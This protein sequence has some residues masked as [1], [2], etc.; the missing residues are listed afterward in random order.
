MKRTVLIL[1]M[2]ASA[3]AVIAQTPAKP[4]TPAKSA[5]GAARI[6][7]AATAVNLPPGVPPVKGLVKTLFLVPLRYQDIKVGDGALA[8]PGKLLKYQFTLWLAADGAKLESTNDHR[9][10]VLDKDKKPVL[11]EDGKPKLS[12][13]QP[14]MTIMGM[15]RPVPGWDM[16]FDGMKAGGKRRVFIPWQLGLGERAIPSHDATHPSIPAKSDLILDIDLAEVTDAPKPPEHPMMA[17]Q[18]HPVPGGGAP[19]P[20]ASGVPAK[21]AAPAAPSAAPAP[22]A[23]ASPAQPQS[24]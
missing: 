22:P 10:P 3:A 1:L 18:A 5:V 13:P 21:P 11:G 20:G 15:G 9:T 16:G 23:P 19:R 12:D 6:T 17:P 2:A 8:E 4:T 14:A 24:K 7:T